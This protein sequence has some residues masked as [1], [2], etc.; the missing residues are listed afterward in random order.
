ANYRRLVGD[1]YWKKT[2][3]FAD[4]CGYFPAPFVTLRTLKSEVIVGLEQNQIA[5]LDSEDS[6]WLINGKRGLIKFLKSPLSF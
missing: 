4:I 1:C 6:Q 3:S 5:Q 2:S